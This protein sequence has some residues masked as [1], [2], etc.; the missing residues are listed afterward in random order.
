[1]IYFDYTACTFWDDAIHT[2]I[3][4]HVV[5]ISEAQHQ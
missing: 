3:P 4:E 1:M 5:A 2:D